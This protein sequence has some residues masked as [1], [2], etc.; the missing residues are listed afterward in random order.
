[1]KKA[2]TRL[3]WCA[4]RQEDSEKLKGFVPPV[5][6]SAGGLLTPQQS[7]AHDIQQE[8]SNEVSVESSLYCNT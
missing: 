2:L 7:S 8:S 1:M 6:Q 4:T 5:E 3:I